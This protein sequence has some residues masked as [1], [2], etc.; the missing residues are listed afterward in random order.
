M[1]KELIDI[2]SCIWWI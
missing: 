1:L 2:L